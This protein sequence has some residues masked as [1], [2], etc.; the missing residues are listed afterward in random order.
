[1]ASGDQKDM[2]LVDKTMSK[3]PQDINPLTPE[4]EHFFYNA[5][6]HLKVFFFSFG[7]MCIEI[8]KL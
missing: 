2:T 3:K 8:N 5:L 6:V 7:L 4:L 1:M